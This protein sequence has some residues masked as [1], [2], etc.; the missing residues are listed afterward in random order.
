M[1]KTFGDKY[2]KMLFERKR[3]LKKLSIMKN[4]KLPP[5]HPGEML[6]EEF[7]VPLKM[8]PEELAEKINVPTKIIKD[9]CQEKKNYERECLEDILESQEKQIK[10]EIRPLPTSLKINGRPRN[11]L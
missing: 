11:H 9:I 4:K 10:K 2:T 8:K 7:L 1:I 3:V 6:R 5:I